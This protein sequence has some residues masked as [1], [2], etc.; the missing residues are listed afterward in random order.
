MK[1]SVRTL[2]Q[3]SADSGAKLVGAAVGS[4]MA[5]RHLLAGG[6]DFIL[7]ASGGRFRIAGVPSFAA[8]TP[9][10]NA[11]RLIMEPAIHEVLPRVGGRPVIIGLCPTDP[12]Y[13]HDDLLRTVKQAG[14]HGV[15]NF[16]SIGFYDGA[17]RRLY[18]NAGYGYSR[19]VAFMAAAAKA[20]LFTLPFVYSEDEA[21]AMAEAGVDA[22]CANLNLPV[23]P[24]PPGTEPVTVAEA[25]FAFT[26]MFAAARK[27][28]PDMYCLFYCA[29]PISTPEDIDAVLQNTGADGYMG[30]SVMERIPSAAAME[31]ISSQYKKII[32]LSHENKHLRRELIRKKGFDEIVGQSGVMQDLYEVVN[33]V[34]DKDVSVLITGESGTGKEL[35]VKAIHYNSRRSDQPFI[36]VNC[37]AIPE[38]LLES[39]LFGHTKGAFTGA[40]GDRMGLF[41]LADKGTLFLDEI[42]EMSLGTQAKLLRVIQQREL[43]R[44][45]SDRVIKLDFRLIVATN[46]NLRE[47]VTQGRF[48]EDLYYRLNVVSIHTPALRTHKEDLPV[49]VSHFLRRIAEKLEQP[50]CRLEPEALDALQAYDWPG[51]VRE[52]EHALESAS[53]LCSDYVIQLKHLPSAVRNSNTTTPPPTRDSTRLF[54][55]DVAAQPE[56]RHEM[57]EAEKIRAT[58][59]TCGWRR[60]QAAKLLGISRKTL[61]NKMQ[62]FKI[63]N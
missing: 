1:Q 14:I 45:G 17:L 62:R 2:F 40:S 4:G 13:N 46:V 20:G 26:K 8:Y 43:Q 24:P 38:A 49:L 53:V 23:G 3:E 36:K 35:V 52:L 31:E 59:A 19:E 15:N 63:G 61:Y 58:L 22:I 5:A 48:R 10:A 41:Q 42:G 7:I 47:V 32:H 60:D 54:P 21:R 28:K 51:N 55:D 34:A 56:A 25:S 11:N 29:G 50:R 57:D 18:E 16:P 27:A 44:I 6:A 9:M 37:A 30:G 33:K 12:T 39:E